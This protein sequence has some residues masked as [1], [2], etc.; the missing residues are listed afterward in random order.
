ML[1]L[2]EAALTQPA[3]WLHVFSIFCAAWVAGILTPGAP[4]SLGIREVMLNQGLV[5]IVGPDG[6]RMTALLLRDATTAADILAF[7]I[8][9]AMLKHA[10]PVTS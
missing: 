8:G 5:P 6:A 2:H 7:I 9:L 3:V 1:S 10:N 4:A